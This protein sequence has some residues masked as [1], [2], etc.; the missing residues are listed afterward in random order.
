[1][2]TLVGQY[3]SPFVR[4][5][6]ITMHLYG[7]PFR[8]NTISVFGDSAE[9]AK[10]NPIVRIPSLVLEDGGVLIDSAAIID[11]LDH[12][13]GPGRALTPSEEPER[14]RVL[15]V[16][17][18][19]TGAVDKL[20]TITYEQH[21]HPPQHVSQE[22]VARCHKQLEGALQ[23]LEDIPKEPYFLGETLTQADITT[24]VMIGYMKLGRYIPFPASRYPTL[25]ALSQR[26]EALEAFVAARPSP[27]ET[28]PTSPSG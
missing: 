13:V 23:V 24:G 25:E 21:F 4:R 10:I 7:L 15:Q 3:D 9:M 5:V 8:R 11:Y 12:R 1:M 2:M 18:Y 19:A 14:Q 20:G 26:L 22:W 27:E 28:M 17:A 6:A 16:V